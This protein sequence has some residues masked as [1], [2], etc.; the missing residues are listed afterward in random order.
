[1]Y[2]F[3]CLSWVYILG[4]KV[5]DGGGSVLVIVKSSCR[6]QCGFILYVIVWE[7]GKFFRGLIRGFRGLVR[8]FRFFFCFVRRQQVRSY[9]YFCGRS[10]KLDIICCCGRS[11]RLFSGSGS[12]CCFLF[13]V[14]IL[15]FIVRF[16]FFFR[17]RLRV[18]YYFWRFLTR[19]SG[20]WLLRQ[21][22]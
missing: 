7:R 6:I 9:F 13:L 20:S 14:R 2:M 8:L 22:R 21:G 5:R 16:A 11:W 3:I 18:G 15:S 10:R 19:G 1:M 17:F 12:R 4:R